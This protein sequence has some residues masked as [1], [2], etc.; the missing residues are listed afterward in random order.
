M[1][2]EPI[3]DAWILSSLAVS[4]PFV[5]MLVAHHAGFTNT[6]INTLYR[7]GG[8]AGI[9]AL[10]LMT[11]PTEKAIYDT[12]QSY[13]GKDPNVHPPGAGNSFPSG[14]HLLPSF[15]LI[16]VNKNYAAEREAGLRIGLP[17]WLS[18]RV[19]PS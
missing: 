14:G 1:A 16:P 3:D 9:L 8:I 6:I 10:P 2:D 4:A 11:L 7:R 18:R 12:V 5:S 15:S 17:L 19:T 13:Q